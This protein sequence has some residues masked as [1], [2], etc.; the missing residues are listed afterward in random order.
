MPRSKKNG[1][2]VVSGF[3][4]GE[5]TIGA[6]NSSVTV[7]LQPA[8]FARL[9][10]I[11]KAYRFFRFT[12]LKLTLLPPLLVSASTVQ[13]QRVLG[14]SYTPEEPVGITGSSTTLILA[15]M[16]ESPFCIVTECYGCYVPLAGTD[17]FSGVPITKPV[18][19][20]VPR[21]VLLDTPVR[22]YENTSG[23]EDVFIAQGSLVWALDVANVAGQSMICPTLYEYTCE[24]SE[25]VNQ[26]LVAPGPHPPRLLGVISPDS[27]IVDV[28]G[29]DD[30][31]KESTGSEGAD[32]GWGARKL[33][34]Q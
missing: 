26:T 15:T 31:S 19:G 2:V 29:P 4:F 17:N 8:V 25:P 18:S 10:N 1:V 23:T 5:P 14:L 11:T 16:S 7:Y 32:A 27:G 21:R 12:R 6:G 28:L 34:L 30:D 20:V 24:F 9:A 22:W 13:A 3:F 33:P